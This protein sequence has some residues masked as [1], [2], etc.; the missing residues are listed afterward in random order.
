MG[1]N[2]FRGKRIHGRKD[3][4]EGCLLNLDEDSGYVYIVPFC[5]RATG[6]PS[7]WYDVSIAHAGRNRGLKVRNAG[8]AW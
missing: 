2:L 3:W 7:W 5:N 1:K 8:G 6:M 4:V